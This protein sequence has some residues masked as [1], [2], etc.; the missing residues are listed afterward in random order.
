MMQWSGPPFSADIV[1]LRQP[2]KPPTRIYVGE[3]KLRMESMDPTGRT[4]LVFDPQH[5]STMLISEKD[6]T[7]IDAGMFSSAI[8][9]AFAPLMHFFRPA[10]TGD[11]CTQWN[12]TVDMYSAITRHRSSGP[13]PH[14]TCQSLGAES[15][16][17][18]PA[19]KW[20]VTEDSHSN[21]GT[22]WID[23]RLHIVSKSM[24]QNGQMEMRNI[25]EGAPPQAM[26]EAPAG[27]Q[28][29]S[30]AGMLSA[31]AKGKAPSSNDMGSKENAPKDSA[32][33]H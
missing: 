22:V 32:A 25:Q 9:V 24:D 21:A 28:K 10:G 31:L 8:A 3:Q 11:P 26:F 5:G 7:Y 13:A 1:D 2:S 29:L 17:G 23:D 19:Q 30:L 4:A 20:A 33:G 18:R 12:S 14:F 15:V 6:R 27:Y 16:S